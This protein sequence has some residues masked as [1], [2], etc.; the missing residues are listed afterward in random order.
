MLIRR[1]G[2]AWHE[3]AKRGY[4]NEA[5]LQSILADH[6]GLI[7]GVAFD[8]LV[9][10]EFQSGVGP[11][12]VVAIDLDG[13]LT[14][15]ECK[16]ASN[17]QIR[18][19]I[20]GQLL[21]YAARLWQMSID[22]FETR[23][24]GRTGE[25]PFGNADHGADLRAQVEDRLRSGAFR[26]ILAVDQINDDL[27]RIV[28]YLNGITSPEVAVIAVVYSRSQDS[29]LEILVPQT[30]GDQIATAKSAQ[31]GPIRPAWTVGNFL[32][33][34]D[35]YDPAAGEP[36]RALLQALT[37]SGFEINGGRASTPSLNANA[38]FIGLGRKWPFCLYTYQRGACVEIR[39]EDF[40]TTPDIAEAFLHAIEQIPGLGIDAAIVRE[41]GYAKRPSL[42]LHDLTVATAEQLVS[43]IEPL[44]A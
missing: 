5:H 16:L 17:P 13:G 24:I 36:A 10:T 33:W 20:I 43:G 37:S 19:E 2:E 8:A 38:P 1:L 28:E 34:I 11:A 42:M 15:V 7:P 30:Y 41:R 23:W 18:R 12:D 4:S 14:I 27:R 40:K 32:E 3:P 31:R 29:D 21:D 26:L 22:E 44:L 25:S 39:F 6:P 35:V 9:C